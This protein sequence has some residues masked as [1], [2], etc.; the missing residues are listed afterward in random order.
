MIT[1][2]IGAASHERTAGRTGHR[3][4]HRPRILCSVGT[5]NYWCHRT[6]KDTFPRTSFAVMET[7]LK[8][9]STRKIVDSSRLFVAFP[10]Q[11]A[12]F[13][14]A[15]QLL[16]RRACGLKEADSSPRT[17]TVCGRSSSY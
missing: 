3:N 5:L 13:F 9:V 1:E 12:P 17:L 10:S 14:L 6:G 11:Y 2:F 7:Y 15:G 8:G 4:G 16:R